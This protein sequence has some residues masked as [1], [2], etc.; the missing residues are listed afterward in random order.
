MTP[1]RIFETLADGLV[2]R[3]AT[4]DDTEAL[5]QFNGAIHADPGEEFAE[6]IARWTRD[7]MN[8]DHPTCGSDDFLLVEDPAAGK[9][10][11]TMC[12]IGQTWAYHGIA[13]PVGRPEIVGTLEGYRR[14]GLVRRMFAIVHQWGEERGHQM[15]FITGIPWY[16]RQFG[17]EMTVNLGGGRQMAA[18]N[19]PDLKEGEQEPVRFRQAAAEDIPFLQSLYDRNYQ[20]DLLVCQRN[21][22]TWRY[23]LT[24]RNKASTPAVVYYIIETPEGKPVGY[25]ATMPVMLGKRMTVSEFEIQPGFSWLAAAYPVM[26]FARGLAQ[27][28]I[29]EGLAFGGSS[30]SN[31][32]FDLG[33]AHPLYDVLARSLPQVR[34]PYAF[35]IRVPDLVGLLTTL[36]PVLEDRLANSYLAGHSGE[37]KLNFYRSGLLLTLEQ[38]KLAGISTWD[39]PHFEGSTANFPDLTFLQ[40]LFGYRDLDELEHAFA[41]LYFSGEGTRYLLRTLFPHQ[42][43]GVKPFA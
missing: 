21:A 24:G 40:L 27:S 11:S 38:G 12:Y 10:V 32:N 28:Y 34:N 26:R 41:D 43:S 18:A 31:L 29:E 30:L 16:Y 20:R 19:I 33:E 14:R 42:V 25:I 6:H 39:Q 4:P 17:Y 15:Q 5:A 37:L 8:N 2:L 3:T 35:Y 9:V 1:T 7:L 22:E 13:I 36:K 23:E